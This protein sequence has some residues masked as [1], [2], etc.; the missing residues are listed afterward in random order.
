[1]TPDWYTLPYLDFLEQRERLMAR[2]IKDGFYRISAK[3]TAV[4]DGLAHAKTLIA[5]GEGQKVEYKSTLRVNLKTGQSD[6]KM[7]F[8][9]LRTIA[10]FLNADGGHLLIGVDD[11]G[12]VLGLE[13]DGFPNEDKM[14]LHLVEM[15][16]NTLGAPNMMFVDNRYESVDGKRVMIVVCRPASQPV[17][18]KDGDHERLYVRTLAATSELSGSHAQHY[19]QSRF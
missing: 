13:A 16:K 8:M 10:G 6:A 2:V 11:S 15:A 18:L 3:G 9:V 4:G 5:A 14:T 7:G 19:I 17:F 12:K 1:L